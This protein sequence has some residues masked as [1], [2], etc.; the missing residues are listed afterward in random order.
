M[1]YEL[2]RQVRVLNPQAGTDEVLDIL[3]GEQTMQAIQPQLETWPENTQIREGHGLI[4]GP[5]LVDLYSHSGEPGHEERETLESLTATAQA[6]GFTRVMVLPDTH[7]AMDE[8][9]VASFLR[10]RLRMTNGRC[11]INFWGALTKGVQGQ[12]MT[13]LKELIN[14]GIVGLADGQPIHD[15]VLLRRILEYLKPLNQPIALFCCDRPLAGNG[16]MREGIA[17]IWN[18]LPGVPLYAETVA[19]SA[20]LELV[21]VLDVPLHLMRISTAR[22]VE[23]I[24]A[25]KAR[26]LPI[27][28][29]T[30]WLHLLLN[31]EA[32]NPMSLGNG[33][34]EF[35][36]LPY[37]PNLRLDPP[38]GNPSDQQALIQAVHEGV[39]DAIAIDHTP[40]TYE[41]KTVAF[42]K[43][44]PGTLGLEFALPLL[45]QKFVTSGQWSALTLWQ[46]LSTKPAECL[47]QALPQIG[48]DQSIELTLFDPAQVW[49]VNSTE[50]SSLSSNTPWLGQQITGRVVKTWL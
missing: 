27:T 33:D 3:I 31:A 8:V 7:P 1:S 14:A 23:L 22:S 12:Q 24:Q 10:D 35:S 21:E 44:P 38:L 45:W 30:T 36:L 6:G 15:L 20:V 17:S 2:L 16:V 46:A 26:Q 42:A 41:E 11:P 37:D 29:S 32:I 50:L 49:T 4:L 13:E 39:I 25:A 47:G 9:T 28:A 19:L 48:L 34:S 43:A 18:G 40:Y 5:G